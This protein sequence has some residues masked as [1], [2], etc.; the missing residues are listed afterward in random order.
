MVLD[1]SIEDIA[2]RLF[3]KLSTEILDAIHNENL[4]Y[5]KELIDS[6][7]GQL[8]KFSLG[9]RKDFISSY[10]QQLNDIKELYINKV[11]KIYLI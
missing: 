9:V 8:T 11:I 5:S 4:K 7:Q 1:N 6:Y 3:N 10:E 2:N